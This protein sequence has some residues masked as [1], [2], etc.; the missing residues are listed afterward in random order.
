MRPF[1]DQPGI[2]LDASRPVRLREVVRVDDKSVLE[3][4]CG[5]RPQAAECIEASHRYVGL[6]IN[7][8]ATRAAQHAVPEG[9]YVTGA[10]EDVQK[11][12]NERF[13][14]FLSIFGALQFGNARQILESARSIATCEATL[15][16]SARSPLLHRPHE[17]VDLARAPQLRP[18]T[19]GVG[20][21]HTLWMNIS[22]QQGW[23]AL[24]EA[25]GWVLID[26]RE[27]PSDLGPTD[28]YTG[29]VR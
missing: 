2:S 13:D 11:L 23:T 4:G 3:L 16:M 19:V 15:V 21:Q 12:F 9:R 14:V 10:A 28:V 17:L 6:D 5:A 26:H 27:V 22:D 29:R 7:P 20:T 1:I 24:L 25:T 8:E 18:Y